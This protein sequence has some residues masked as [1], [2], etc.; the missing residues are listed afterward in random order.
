MSERPTSPKVVPIRPA[1]RALERFQWIAEVLADP[2][3]T[4]GEVRILMRLAMHQNVETGTL[5]VGFE[6]LARGANQKKRKAVATIAKAARLGTI[7]RISRGG[8]GKANFYNLEKVHAC[9]PFSVK[10]AQAGIE[11]PSKGCMPVHP[12][13]EEST[14]GLADRLNRPSMA[15]LQAKHPDLL[16]PKN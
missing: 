14:G 11:T 4:D 8:R 10:G 5:F 12:Y 15:E 1:S 3:Y 16:K 2:R 6:K 7:K 13:R 9:A